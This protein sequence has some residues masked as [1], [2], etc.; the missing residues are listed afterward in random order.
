MASSLNKKWLFTVALMMIAGWVGYRYLTRS[1][2]V[3]TRFNGAY[4]FADGRLGFVSPRDFE[5]LRY[6]EMSGT[7]RTLW[8]TGDATFESGPGWSGREPVEVTVDFDLDDSEDSPTGFSWITSEGEAQKAT[9]IAL[10]EIFTTFPSGEL[11]LRGKLVLPLGKAPFPVVVLVHGSEKY[12]AVDGYFLPY[13]FASHGI[14]TLVFDKRGTGGST[15][16]YNQNF[17]ALSDDV[18]AAVDWLRQ[19]PE[20]DTAN[21]HLAGYSQ[22]GWIAPLAATKTGAIK[23][24]L[25]NYGPMVPITGEDRWGYVLALQEKGFDDDA[26]AKVDQINDVVS[27]IMDDGEN[28]WS[29]LAKK[30]DAAEGEAWFEAIA[31]SDSIVGYLA[32]TKIPLWAMRI[33]VWWISRGDIPFVDRRYD[34]VP[35]VASLDIPSLWLFGEDDSSMPTAWSIDELEV[36]QREGRPVELKIF[37]LAEHGILLMKETDSG[38]RQPMGYA[39]GYFKTQVDWLRQQ[40]GLASTGS[41]AVSFSAP[42][43]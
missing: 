37:P 1:K 17:Y 34:P 7:S 9:K 26:I 6:R 38:E 15:G 19:R 5:S 23:S 33:L 36:L 18:V 21:I 35:T 12:S 14:A 28:R 3:D 39:P 43:R 42:V 13:L 32:G 4:R 31:G 20:I 30:L 40:S 22:G 25:I 16:K 41:V 29:E 27:A 11:S 2:P 8:P 10:P 24:L